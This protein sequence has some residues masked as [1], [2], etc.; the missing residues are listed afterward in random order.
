MRRVNKTIQIFA[1]AFRGNIYTRQ[2]RAFD[3]SRERAK[4][5]DEKHSSHA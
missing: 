3:V 4:K 2:T 1:D 5:R